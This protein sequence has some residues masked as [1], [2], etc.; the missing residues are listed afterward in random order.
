MKDVKDMTFFE[1]AEKLVKILMD[2]TQNRNALFFRVLVAYYLTKIT[3]MM[4]IDIKTH[5]RGN[6]PVSMYA[7]NLSTSGT[8]KG[9]ATNIVEEQVINQFRTRF[10]EETFPKVSEKNLARLAI[11]RAAKTGE[12]QDTVL[13]KVRKEFEDLGELAFSFDGGT[14]PAVKQMRHKLLMADAGSVN[15]EIDEIGSNMSGNVEV[16]NTFLELFDVG[17]VKQKL[18]KNTSENKRNVEIDGR[19]P[20]NM[21]LFGTPS[22]LLN[23]GREESEFYAMLETGYA[24]RCIFGYHKKPKT[25]STMTE[26]ALYDMLTNPKAADYL[27]E[28]SNKLARLAD[29]INFNQTLSISKDVSLQVLRYKLDCDLLAD[30]M[31]EHEDIP[32]AEMSHRYYKALK[33]AGTYA[34]IDGSH[35]VKE[36][37]LHSAIKLVEESGQAFSK[38][39]TRERNYVKLAK[40]LAN[41]GRE[42]TQVDLVEDL[43]FYRGAE[44]QKRELMALAIA[45]GYKNNI[46]IKKT[47]DQNIEFLTGESMEVTSL[48]KLTLSYGTDITKDFKADVAPFDQLHK[49]VR[50]PNYHY[51]AHHFLDGYR[52]STNLIQGFNMVILDIDSGVNLLTAQ[53]LL[54]GYKCLFTTTKR[55]TPTLNRFRIIMPLSHK[56]KLS[57]E[58]YAQFMENVFNWLPFEV[59]TATKDCARKWQSFDGSHVYQDGKLLDA[60]LFIPQTRKEEEQAQVIMDTNG[61]SNMERWFFL[62]TDKG[63]RSNQLI[64]YAL[65]LVDNGFSIEGARNGVL[66]F[67]SKLKDKL[68]EDE[69]TQTI[70][71]TVIK[72]VTKRDMKLH[73][74]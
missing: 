35:E 13:D 24:R 2:R 38:I 1:P 9:F 15:L 41:V 70:M 47:Y 73:A 8:G 74:A 58:V 71:V 67:N 26:N 42:V 66:Q 53:K 10:L 25:D 64:R 56:V 16:L 72:A 21:M 52:N 61:L 30:K 40:Y 49:L 63:N 12:D 19:T 32:K 22:K 5:D 6:I 3:S 57:A 65:V 39:L 29:P 4:R 23:G 48:D 44:A 68:T 17:K 43:Q 34:F 46:I 69:I 18:I 28:L 37:H 50:L 45:Y 55:H 11:K 60:T 14:S 31:K 54:D 7:I 33:L 27:K 20:T 51:T 36:A 59:D 62:N